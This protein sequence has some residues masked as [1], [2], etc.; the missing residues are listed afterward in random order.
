[1]KSKHLIVAALMIASIM[2]GAAWVGAR[3]ISTPYVIHDGRRIPGTAV[4]ADRT[5][6]IIL[7][8]EAGRMTF[9][10][11]T[12]VVVDEPT[13]FQELRRMID[14]GRYEEAMPGLREIIE[15][16][17]FLGWD[18]RA[19]RLLGL[20]LT[21]S[22]RYTDAVASFETLFEKDPGA[23]AE[24]E[25]QESY[26]LALEGAGER[27]KLL[28]MLDEVIRRG[29]RRPAARAQ[30]IRGNLRL[31]EGETEMALYDFLRTA[32]FFRSFIELQPEALYRTAD[33]FE[34]LGRHEKAERFIERLKEEFPESDYA[35]RIAREQ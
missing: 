3:E 16:Y 13:N 10:P 24:P 27:D 30:M 20:A 18:H 22:G 29:E 7:T 21:G 35:Q 33:C 34:R 4:R 15:Q 19:R 17:R 5:G 11:G 25:I 26:L 6:Q 32:T 28:P 12:R 23:R 31:E 9:E 14:A 8:T 2:T 1:M